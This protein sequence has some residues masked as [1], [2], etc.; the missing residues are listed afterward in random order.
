MMR[1]F[2]Y[3]KAL[4]APHYVRVFEHHP[5]FCVVLSLCRAYSD[6]SAGPSKS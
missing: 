4:V 2:Y 6:K 3:T 1:L 5:H